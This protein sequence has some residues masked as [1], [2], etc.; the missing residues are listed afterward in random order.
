M[1]F[2]GIL[3]YLPGYL[4]ESLQVSVKHVKVGGTWTQAFGVKHYRET[5]EIGQFTPTGDRLLSL[6]QILKEEDIWL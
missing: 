4:L 6:L 1:V 2:A 5:G 3:E